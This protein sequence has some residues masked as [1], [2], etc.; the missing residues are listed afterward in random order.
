MVGPRIYA[1]QF[2]NRHGEAWEFEY[3]PVKGEGVL[4]GADV[5]WQEYRVLD[6]KVPGLIL[7]EEELRWLRTAWE[8]AISGH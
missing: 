4:R 1:S 7:N 5:N 3:I 8:E 2:K 6:G